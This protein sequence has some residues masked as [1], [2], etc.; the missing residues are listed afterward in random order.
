MPAKKT[1]LPR[2]CKLCGVEFTPPNSKQEL[3]SRA[4]KYVSQSRSTRLELC[5]RGHD[6]TANRRANGTCKT[7]R[8]EDS[9]AR[10][11]AGRKRI[12]AGWPICRNGHSLTPGNLKSS[13]HRRVCLTCHRDNERARKRAL[14]AKPFVRQADK[15]HCPQGHPLTPETRRRG[16]HD[17][18]CAVCH[19]LRASGMQQRDVRAYASVLAFD[20]CSYCGRPGGVFDH[21]V[22][23][24]TGG[25]DAW[26]NLTSSCFSC[27]SRKRTKSLLR[28]L[29]EAT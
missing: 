26:D 27:N 17:G 12:P 11:L 2:G 1:I 19:R 15:T 18:Q 3:C 28:F 14:G 10:T 16:R 23:R 20:P 21:I 6:M 24:S 22:A 7:C 9:Q 29:C 8:R 4:C 25:A 13:A 5:A